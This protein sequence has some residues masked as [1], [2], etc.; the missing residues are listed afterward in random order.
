MVEG[1][2]LPLF[3]TIP[4]HYSDAPVVAYFLYAPKH[5]FLARREY[6]ELLCSTLFDTIKQFTLKISILTIERHDIICNKTLLTKS[7]RDNP[8]KQISTLNDIL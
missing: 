8:S 4:T 3:Y 2:H 6:P 7:V 5:D 1:P